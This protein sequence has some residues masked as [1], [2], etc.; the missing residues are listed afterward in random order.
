MRYT[1]NPL[2]V[3]FEEQVDGKNM[4]M[5]SKAAQKTKSPKKKCSMLV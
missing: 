1:A 5:S 4:L 3:V 2:A